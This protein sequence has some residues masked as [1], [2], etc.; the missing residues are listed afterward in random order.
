M[1]NGLCHHSL[2]L[3]RGLYRGRI[4]SAT[5]NRTL[6]YFQLGL[7]EHTWSLAASIQTS[8]FLGHTSHPFMMVFLAVC[9]RPVTSSRRAAAIH[10]GI[11]H[12][13]SKVKR[14]RSLNARGKLGGGGMNN[15]HIPGACFGF[16]LMTDL[17]N[18]RAFFTSLHIRSGRGGRTNISQGPSSSQHL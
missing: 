4:S 2:G 12:Y 1:S 18:S 8:S 11:A 6:D 9:I 13:Q 15:M 7:N 10:P 17:S 16:V 5:R 14:Q 3:V